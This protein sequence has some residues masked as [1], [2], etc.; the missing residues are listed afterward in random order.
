V[1]TAPKILHLDAIAS[2]HERLASLATPFA[3]SSTEN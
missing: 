2:L 1:E 3:Q